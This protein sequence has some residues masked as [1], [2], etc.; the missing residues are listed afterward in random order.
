[1]DE[2]LALCGFD[3]D[4]VDRESPRLQ[5]TFNRLGITEEDVLRGKLRLAT[6][7]D[8]DLQG[9][10]K[11]LRIY[12]KELAN[13]VLAR[14]EG[15]KTV[16]HACMAGGFETVGSAIVSHRS[17]V[18]VEVPNPIF[19]VVLGSIF[20]KFVPILEAAERLWLKSGVVAHCGMVKSR[21]GLIALNLIPRPDMMVTSGLLCETSP[22]T[23]DLIHEVY[24]IDTYCYD[25][26]Q[27]RE[28][29]E[30]P[31]AARTI[32]L[33]AQS[34]KKTTRSL[35]G[36]IGFD[37]SDGMIWEALHARSLY[38]QAMGKVFNLV[39]TGDPIPMSPTH[40][41]LLLWMNPLALTVD[42]LMEATEAVNLLH[43]ELQDRIDRGIGVTQKGAPRILG[44][45]PPHHADPPA[46]TSRN[47]HGDGPCRRRLRIYGPCQRSG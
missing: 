46:G 30:Y 36:K 33:A 5:K 22:K 16:I 37:L 13:M 2:F 29:N 20:D 12:M 38:G 45:L 26:C 24:D 3:K 35:M 32:A 39:R 42:G 6:Y 10:R 8:M 19:M 14:D 28:D 47:L 40:E 31:D 41:N 23:N 9:I 1:M 43:G 7:F 11:L 25:T 21:L 17:D 18:Y 27:D 4:E 15:K 44:I 34:M